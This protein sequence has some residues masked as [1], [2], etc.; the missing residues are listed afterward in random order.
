MYL[1]NRKALVLFFVP[2]LI[3]LYLVFS[4]PVFA[5]NSYYDNLKSYKGLDGTKYLSLTHPEDFDLISWF[6][7]NI[8][9]QPV[10]IEAVGDSYTDYSRISANTGL[11]TVVGWPVH[12]WLWRGTY[13]VVGPRVDD[14]K[15]F[16]TTT[17]IEKAKEII[18]KYNVSYVVVSLLEKEKYPDLNEDNIKTLGEIIYQK[19]NAKLYKVNF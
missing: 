15:T 7:I 14:V 1:N 13:D 4:Y 2:T 5:I 8:K 17:D 9:G 18:K 10:V 19:G 6:N 16:Y 11:P 3:L 12:E